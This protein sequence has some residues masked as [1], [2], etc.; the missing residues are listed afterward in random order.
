[1]CIYI[2]I[3]IYLYLSIY[4]HIYI[5]VDIS[6]KLGAHRTP[7]GR[8][9]RAKSNGRVEYGRPDNKNS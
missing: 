4:I 7:P 1:M 3:Y 6:E 8:G 5:Y 9:R 2:Y